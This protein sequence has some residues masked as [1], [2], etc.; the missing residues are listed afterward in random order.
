MTFDYI[1]IGSGFAGSV[2]AKLLNNS[3][4][5]ERNTESTAYKK[6]ISLISNSYVNKISKNYIGCNKLK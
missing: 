2:L 4:I 3:C 5:I 6:N 1:I